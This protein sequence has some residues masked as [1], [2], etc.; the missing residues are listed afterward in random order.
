MTNTN[1]ISLEKLLTA[2]HSPERVAARRKEAETD[3][4]ELPEFEQRK[5][6]LFFDVD[7]L[8]FIRTPFKTDRY[9]HPGGDWDAKAVREYARRY[10]E[11][12]VKQTEI[13]LL[14]RDMQKA[15]NDPELEMYARI[16]RA[17]TTQ[18]DGIARRKGDRESQFVARVRSLLTELA[19]AEQ[20]GDEDA[21]RS[22]ERRLDRVTGIPYPQLPEAAWTAAD[23]MPASDRQQEYDRLEQVY[24]PRHPKSNGA[25]KAPRR[26]RLT[27]RPLVGHETR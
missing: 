13:E 20:D 14:A 26:S 10:R 9:G 12:L 4:D 7:T 24:G 16:N 17:W 19:E 27:T 22:C 11:A 23:L 2:V 8:N 15:Y 1:K 3:V 25:G 21:V 18:V 6:S 5:K